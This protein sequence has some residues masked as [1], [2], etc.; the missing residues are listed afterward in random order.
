MWALLC[1]VNTSINLVQNSI[2]L[3]HSWYVFT[4]ISYSIAGF[5]DSATNWEATS[6]S[7]L[8]SHQLGLSSF[9]SIRVKTSF[10]I[11]LFCA[12]IVNVIVL[13]LLFSGFSDSAIFFEVGQLY[14]NIAATWWRITLIGVL[15]HLINFSQHSIVSLDLLLLCLNI[16]DSAYSFFRVGDC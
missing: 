8:R 2:V 6:Y 10:K 14:P 11:A 1:Y 7:L 9:T 12:I 15:I 5:S 4:V 13:F 3:C 16:S